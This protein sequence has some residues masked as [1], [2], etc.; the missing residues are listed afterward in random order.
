MRSLLSK[1]YLKIKTTVTSSYIYHIVGSPWK[2]MAKMQKHY[3]KNGWIL[4]IILNLG[5]K[6]KKA[7]DIG[8][9][10]AEIIDLL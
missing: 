10:K 4:L 6:S 2:L 9:I 3:F 5:Y 7:N 1:D 8:T